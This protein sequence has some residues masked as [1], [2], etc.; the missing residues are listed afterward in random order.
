MSEPLNVGAV[1]YGRM[2]WETHR[3]TTDRVWVR[4]A[5]HDFAPWVSV[6]DLGNVICMGWHHLEVSD[7]NPSYRP[8]GGGQ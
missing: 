4:M 1:V 2:R 7:R 3:A 6:D 5:H 8:E